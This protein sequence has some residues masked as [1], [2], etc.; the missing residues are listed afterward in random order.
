MGTG[1]WRSGS[2]TPDP[3]FLCARN[4]DGGRASLPRAETVGRC[5]PATQ[6]G[7]CPSRTCPAHAQLGPRRLRRRTIDSVRAFALETGRGYPL[8]QDVWGRPRQDSSESA[9]ITPRPTLMTSCDGGVEH[10]AAR[11]RRASA[12]GRRQR[13][14]CS[15]RPCRPAAAEAAGRR[16]S[17]ARARGAPRDDP[18]PSPGRGRRIVQFIA[19]RRRSDGAQQDRRGARRPGPRARRL[20]RHEGRAHPLHRGGRRRDHRLRAPRATPQ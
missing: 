18:P 9:P 4:Q 20:H 7:M 15:H 8:G 6:S 12:T 2:M 10:V 1:S 16:E 5:S 13:E 3:T 11:T 19:G 14:R 17:D